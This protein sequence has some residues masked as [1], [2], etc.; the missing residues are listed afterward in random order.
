[1]PALCAA[2]VVGVDVETTGLD[3]FTDR[4]RLV[5]FALADRVI[6]VDADQVPLQRLAPVLGA[7]HMLVFHNAKFDIKMLRAA[8]LPWPTAPLFDTMLAA[9][10]LGASAER[11][12]A[13]HYTL[14][15][16]GKRHLDLALD[17][18]LQ[19]SDWRGALTPAQICYAARDADV[20]L[21]LTPVLQQ[22]LADA[23][24]ERV[25]AVEFACV[26]ALAWLEMAG[27]PI[28]AQRWRDRAMLA[29]HQAQ[30]LEAEL[31]ALLHQSRNGCSQLFPEGINWRSTP[32]VL[33]LLQHRGHAV[34]NTA[35][36]T[37]GAL[38]DADPVI[39][40]LLQW[41][42]SDKRARTYGLAWLKKHVHPVTGRVHADYHQLGSVAGRMSCTA[43]N[44]QNLPRSAGYRGSIAAAPGSC[45]VKTDYSQIEL[46]I[47]ALL[48]QDAAMLQAY[49][50]GEDLHI[51]TA[52]RILGVAPA[53][54]TKKHRPLAKS[55]N[56]GLIYGMGA[57]TLQQKAWKDYGVI[58]ALDEAEHYRQRFFEAYPDLRRWQ[59]TTGDSPAPDSRTLLGRR[60]SGVTRFTERLNTPVQGSGADGFKLALATLFAHRHE[61]PDARL[62][63]V[64]HD[65][66]VAECPMEAAEA[67]A[68]WLQRHMTAAMSEVVDHA[69]PVVV[70][71]SVGQ[72]W[73][74]TPLPETAAA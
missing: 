12:P 2:P 8:G 43:P 15:A 70:E 18:T 27:A 52:A 1:L 47:A 39:R 7:A 42:E 49:H 50:A 3:P 33:K 19:K 65:E 34:P 20:T 13:G 56:F 51:A 40:A 26:L 48:A 57:K 45:V 10:L 4:L 53:Q 58:M 16:V 74:G 71:T 46:R 67:T 35:S 6:V 60:R 64:I 54:V 59:R 38:V 9:Q 11:P 73:A 21:Q 5:Q 61:V 62:I 72:D 37:L 23:G 22:A 68:Q 44:F 28:D 14:E 69:V 55:V 24:L 32:Q 36:E 41:R 25:A 31:H 66:I 30:A 63:A 17:K 29:E